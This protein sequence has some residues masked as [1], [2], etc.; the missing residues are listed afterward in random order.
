MASLTADAKADIVAE[1]GAMLEERGRDE[2][3]EIAELKVSTWHTLV[4]SCMNVGW[5]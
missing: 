5:M 4:K 2:L 3:V 1:I